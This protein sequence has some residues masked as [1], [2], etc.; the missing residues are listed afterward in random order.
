MGNRKRKISKMAGLFE[1]DLRSLLNF[2]RL[3]KS[4]QS[5]LKNVYS[6]LSISLLAATAGAYVHMYTS[7]MQAGLLT[8][9]GS[10]GLLMALMFT[11]HNKENTNKRMGYM[12]GFAFCSGMSLGPLMEMVIRIDPSIVPTALMGTSLIFICFTMASLLSS[13]RKFLYMGGMLM[14]GLS[15]LMMMSLGNL[16]FRS[17]FMFEVELYLGFAIM[18][19]FVLYDTQLIVEKR[20]RG[21]D[22]F[23]W[24]SVDLFIDFIQIFR[25]LMIILANKENKKK[26]RRD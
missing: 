11:P 5:H 7:L 25:R 16:F 8:M 13:D 26:N 4:V 2:D 15:M 9:F 14:S 20:R 1:R 12:G 10:I 21:D 23:I 24:H 6:C 3:E 18:C 19:A 22:D 17:Q